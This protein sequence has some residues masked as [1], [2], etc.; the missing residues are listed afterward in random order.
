MNINK[1]TTK[2][3]VNELMKRE[4]VKEFRVDPYDEYSLK[5]KQKETQNTG[6]SIILVIED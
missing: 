3:L 6:P 4:G 5:I 1:F 2:E